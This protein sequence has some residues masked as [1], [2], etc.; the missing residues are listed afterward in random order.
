MYRNPGAQIKDKDFDREAYAQQQGD[1][2]KDLIAKARAKLPAKQP[3]AEV[4][5]SPSKAVE[6]LMDKIHT[7]RSPYEHQET[8]DT[9]MAGTEEGGVLLGYPVGESTTALPSRPSSQRRA[10]NMADN[11]HNRYDDAEFENP[12]LPSSLQQYPNKMPGFEKDAAI[13]SDYSS[14]MANLQS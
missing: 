4:P 10:Q 9:D 6:A 11:D 2:F 14:T 5:G 1:S 7:Y 13:N 12:G 3:V 8:P